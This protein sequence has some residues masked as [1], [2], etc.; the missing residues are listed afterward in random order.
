MADGYKKG[1]GFDLRTKKGKELQKHDDA[2]KA[3]LGA[4][5]SRIIIVCIILYA[6]IWVIDCIFPGF[7]DWIDSFI[8]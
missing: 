6:I 8:S 5:I 4:W 7:E 2:Y 1:G 3:K